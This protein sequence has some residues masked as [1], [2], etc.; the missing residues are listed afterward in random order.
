MALKEKIKHTI[1]THG[2][3][4]NKYKWVT[5][6]KKQQ[7]TINENG[8]ALGLISVNRD[9]LLDSQILQCYGLDHPPKNLPCVK[10]CNS[11][12][13][14][15]DLSKR[16]IK[17]SPV[18]E[19][20]DPGSYI[21]LQNTAN[22][23][24][25]NSALQAL[26]HMPKFRN[27]I[28]RITN[29]V[30]DESLKSLHYLLQATF[31]EMDLCEYKAVSCTPGTIL[32]QLS[33]FASRQIMHKDDDHE[34]LKC[35]SEFLENT[36]DTLLADNQV[37]LNIRPLFNTTL[38]RVARWTCPECFCEHETRLPPS[39]TYNIA[40]YISGDECP[41]D[42]CLMDLQQETQTGVS[43]VCGSATDSIGGCGSHVKK[44]IACC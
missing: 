10:K 27:T 41:L 25:I 16:Q 37:G 13:C 24:W 20:R 12:Y 26:Y 35:V 42:H 5:Q 6:F 22:T 7:E 21:G 30:G 44:S 4:T 17:E 23:C 43:Q 38:A 8:E 34:D 14:M 29:F 11:P 39:T 9:Q 1:E 40:A 32:E 31:V 36:I 18:E 28:N 19:K 15:C 33:L 2:Y 3:Q